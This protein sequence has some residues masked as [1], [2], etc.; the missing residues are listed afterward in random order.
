MKTENDI[1]IE[2]IN[3]FALRHS[4]GVRSR[5]IANAIPHLIREDSE[6]TGNRG[7]GFGITFS[8]ETIGD[9]SVVL[10]TID[11]GQRFSL[12]VKELSAKEGN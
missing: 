8:A 3:A 1:Q 10:V 9:A 11:N 7:E 5:D 12:V 2:R 6:V 4:H